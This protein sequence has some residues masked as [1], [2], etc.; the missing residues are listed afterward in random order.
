MTVRT[1]KGLR[2]IIGNFVILEL[3]SPPTLPVHMPY[4]GPLVSLCVVSWSPHCR[5]NQIVPVRYHSTV[6]RLAKHV[7]GGM[8]I[9]NYCWSSKYLFWAENIDPSKSESAKGPVL[10]MWDSVAIVQGG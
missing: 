4:S 10:I 7:V 3:R 2:Q 5:A 8:D 6:A 1:P 9:A